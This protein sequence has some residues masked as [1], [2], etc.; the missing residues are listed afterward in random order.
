MSICC[1][2]PVECG[3]CNSCNITNS[4]DR[5]KLLKMKERL[6]LGISMAKEQHDIPIREIEQLREIVAHLKY[7]IMNMYFLSNICYD[8][9][10]ET[11]TSHLNFINE[12]ET[13]ISYFLKRAEQRCITLGRKSVG[14]CGQFSS[15]KSALINNM[16]GFNDNHSYMLPEA[17]VPTTAI[18]TYA[19]YSSTPKLVFEN[20]KNNI[21]EDHVSMLGSI[22]HHS[23]QC[24]FPWS[25]IVERL[26]YFSRQAHA[27][28]VCVDLPGFNRDKSL[29]GFTDYEASINSATSCDA[30]VYLVNNQQGSLSR[31]D[32]DFLKKL[33]HYSIPILIVI[34]KID[35][36]HKNQAMNIFNKVKTDLSNNE[37]EYTDIILHSSRPGEI[38]YDQNYQNQIIKNLGIIKEFINEQKEIDDDT[39]DILFFIKTMFD[40]LE[41]ADKELRERATDLHNNLTN[42]IGDKKLTDDF[43]KRW[44]S[45]EKQVYNS[46]HKYLITKETLFTTTKE[47]DINGF[48]GPLTSIANNFRNNEYSSYLSPLN[49]SFIELSFINILQYIDNVAMTVDHTK[50]TVSSDS[51]EN[52]QKYID[53]VRNIYNTVLEQ[54]DKIENLSLVIPV[55]LLKEIESVQADVVNTFTKLKDLYSA[56]INKTKENSHK[57]VA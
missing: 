37:I 44:K 47:F 56:I 20:F 8:L 12:F 39:C 42:F 14:F 13:K 35:I 17:A 54:I 3:Q 50:S 27:N 11:K 18:P 15:G 34:S 5:I 38:D 57:L 24:G 10:E 55:F 25:S 23:Q 48:R 36:I 43:F 16:F 41:E 9:D 31:E 51:I 53:S 2:L 32:I 22:R 49:Y 19:I 4:D 6:L 7:K 21:Y 29:A 1:N 33:N 52:E 26:Y 40:R 30:V 45:I 28:V 46:D